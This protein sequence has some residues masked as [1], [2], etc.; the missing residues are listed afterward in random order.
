M[1]NLYDLFRGY[2]EG[3]FLENLDLKYLDKVFVSNQGIYGIKVFKKVHDL[4]MDWE[5]A[6][7]EFATKFQRKLSGIVDDLRWDM[8][9]VLYIDEEIS[10]AHRKSIEKNKMFFR[11]IILTPNEILG[12]SLSFIL[13]I[14]QKEGDFIFNHAQFLDQLKSELQEESLHKLGE[15][16][17]NNGKKYS[18][19][20]IYKLFSLKKEEN[21][22]NKED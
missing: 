2:K 5:H 8:Y 18:E 7:S 14:P 16:F 9:L 13:D 21:N 1:D 20:E 6:Q 22:E 10:V 15:D 19:Q 3:Y 4:L 11:K 12:S 17:F